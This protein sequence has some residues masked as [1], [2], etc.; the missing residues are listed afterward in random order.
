MKILI[1]NGSPR[2]RFS[3]TLQSCLYLEKRFHRHSFEYLNVGAG[4]ESFERDM[5]P[6]AA[7]FERAELV[8]F[9]YPV[10]SFLV[11]YQLHRFVEHSFLLLSGHMEEERV[12]LL[13]ARGGRVLIV[14]VDGT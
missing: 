8:I 3:V 1:V 13:P 7:A 6:A 11:P 14:V 9:A 5:R 12:V 2:G 4:I 10:Y